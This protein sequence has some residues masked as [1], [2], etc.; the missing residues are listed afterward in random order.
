[1]A[2]PR[3]CRA[4]IDAKRQIWSKAG[5]GDERNAGQ[6]EE[7]NAADERSQHPPSRGC[8]GNS[9][10]TCGS[11]NTAAGRG[12][13]NPGLQQDLEMQAH[14]LCSSPLTEEQQLPRHGP[15]DPDTGVRTEQTRR[16]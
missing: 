4:E 13:T 1:M 11:L 7:R 9:N 8:Q 14:G 3:S 12:N 15:S 5:S 16:N 2:P 10:E 6:G